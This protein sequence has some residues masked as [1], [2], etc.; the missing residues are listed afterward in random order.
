MVNWVHG[1]VDHNGLRSMVNR[2]QGHGVGSLEHLLVADSSHGALRGWGECDNA[3]G[4]LTGARKVVMQWR[5]GGKA[6][7]PNGDGASMISCV[8]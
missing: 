4:V 1:P 5:I 6:S 2:G 3:N 8:S 7:A